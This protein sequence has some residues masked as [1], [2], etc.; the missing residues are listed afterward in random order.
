MA[1]WRYISTIPDLGSRRPGDHWTEGSSGHCRKEKNYF[2][3]PG[4]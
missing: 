2:L 4:I 1:E 3:L